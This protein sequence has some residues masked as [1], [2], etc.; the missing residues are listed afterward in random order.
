LKFCF[1]SFKKWL[2][3]LLGVEDQ[4]EPLRAPAGQIGKLDRGVAEQD[5]RQPEL[6]I[7]MT[8]PRR[9]EFPLDFSARGAS[10]AWSVFEGKRDA[11]FAIRSERPSVGKKRTDSFVMGSGC[12]K[13]RA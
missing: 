1:T 8:L 12:I 9:G 2:G 13:L 4:S 3:S 11:R 5:G 6:S 7:E 10:S